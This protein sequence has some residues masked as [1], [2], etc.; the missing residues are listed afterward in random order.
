MRQI[1]SEVRMFGVLLWLNITCVFA[2]PIKLDIPKLPAEIKL[3]EFK[4]YDFYSLPAALKQKPL[5]LETVDLQIEIGQVTTKYNSRGEASYELELNLEGGPITR[6]VTL[7][8][9]RKV[10]EVV[11]ARETVYFT[12]NNYK[13][14][15]DFV[16]ALRLEKDVRCSIGDKLLSLYRDYDSSKW[17]LSLGRASKENIGSEHLGGCRFPPPG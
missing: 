6:R 1:E 15:L 2:R 12:H 5:E 8:V 16:E 7:D 3:S 17:V 14:L 13:F 10:H 4:D 11:I 9:A